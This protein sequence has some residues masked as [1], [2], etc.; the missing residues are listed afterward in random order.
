[1]LF[2]PAHG[3]Y[4]NSVED[5]IAVQNVSRDNKQLS[6]FSM[7]RGLIRISH[8][9][10]VSMGVAP[11]RTRIKAKGGVII[12]IIR[13]IIVMDGETIRITCHHLE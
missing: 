5:N 12:R 6:M 4:V 11:I 9:N 10:R 8:S 3:S 7:C 1:M 13:A 2:R